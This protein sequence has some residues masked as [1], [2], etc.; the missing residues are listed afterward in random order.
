M[1]KKKIVARDASNKYEQLYHYTDMVGAIGI[2]DSQSLWCTDLKFLND[3]SEGQI[4]REKLK[5]A[6]LPHLIKKINQ[7]IKS[8]KM[9]GEK[10][11]ADGGLDYLVQQEVEILVD[12]SYKSM[13]G[14][15]YITSMCG[16]KKDEN[17]YEHENGLLSQWRGYGEDGGVA[18]VFNAKEIEK[19]QE[20]ECNQYSLSMGLG[21]VF[22]DFNHGDKELEK[23]SEG[24]LGTFVDFAMYQ[25][26]N[27]YFK[28]EFE[29]NEK[30]AAD[31]YN[32]LFQCV[33]RYKHQSFKE[34]NEVRIY[35]H[36][37]L[38]DLGGDEKKQKPL[39]FHGAAIPY[40]ELFDS[41]ETTLPIEGVIVGPHRDKDRRAEG[42]RALLKEK[43]LDVEVVISKTPYIE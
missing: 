39:K 5:E 36:R 42:L 4:A 38:T 14:A 6:V 26:N 32:A 21:D 20:K 18:I 15:F 17:L 27:A 30:L 23:E 24:L 34:E 22:Y 3:L 25:F 31:A 41:E 13:G 19:I 11:N 2:I 7:H 37:V 43:K 8:G 28:N 29:T 9:D 12:V 33:S 40:I 10:I 16:K 1:K 35:A